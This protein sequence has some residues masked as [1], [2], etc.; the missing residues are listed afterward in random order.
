MTAKNVDYLNI[1]LILISAILAFNFPMEVFVIAFIVIGPLHYFTEINWLDQKNYFIPGPKRLW[2]WVGIASSVLIMLPKFYFY[3]AGPNGAMAQFMAD[4]NSWT[5]ALIFLSLIAAAGFVLIQKKFYWILL[6][7]PSLVG[8]FYL[9]ASS[10]Y[11][12]WVG[13]F[14][15]TIIHVYFFTLLFMAFGAKKS[16]SKPGFVAI[17]LALFVPLFIASSQVNPEAYSFS[18]SMTN[19]YVESGFHQTPYRAAN[20]LGFIENQRGFIHQAS[21]MKMMIFIA[22]IYLYH[23]LN[24]FSKTS[25]IQWHKTLTRKRTLTIACTWAVLMLFLYLDYKL[26]LLT[27]IFFSMLHVILEFPLNIVSIQGLFRQKKRPKPN[28]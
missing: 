20:Y 15:P 11:E 7:I 25:L 6:G 22:F 19:T 24:W 28:S 5:N 14:L 27:A 18:K 13:V 21:G 4:F 1:G 12:Q 9:N 26:G 2:F 23:Y 16:G 3:L 8:A 17:A 10:E